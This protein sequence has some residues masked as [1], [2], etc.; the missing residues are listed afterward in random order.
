MS[1]S[2][3]IGKSDSFKISLERV[4]SFGTSYQITDKKFIGFHRIKLPGLFPNNWNE[5]LHHLV[6]FI[7][8]RGHFN[9]VINCI[10]RR[11]DPLHSNDLSR[12]K[13]VVNKKKYSTEIAVIN[14]WLTCCAILDGACSTFIINGIESPRLNWPFQLHGKFKLIN[15]LPKKKSV[16]QIQRKSM[17]LCNGSEWN[18]ILWFTRHK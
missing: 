7:L 10:Y 2:F 5:S 17:N 1:Y 16:S 14:L 12:M 4:K 6:E 18:G 11:W 15:V 3:I 8:E 9:V 13:I